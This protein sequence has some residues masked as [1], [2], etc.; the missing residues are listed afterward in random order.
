MDLWLVNQREK[1]FEWKRMEGAISD[2]I[3]RNDQTALFS[4][5]SS[6]VKAHGTKIAYPIIW[7]MIRWIVKYQAN[8]RDW[9]ADR[10][11][12]TVD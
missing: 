5:W 11:V 2:A 1:L 12:E 10:D 8:Y 4:F 9:R 3:K 6:L 7:M